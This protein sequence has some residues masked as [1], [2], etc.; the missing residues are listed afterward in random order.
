V[1]VVL[2]ALENEENA[3]LDLVK[4]AELCQANGIEFIA[5]PIPDRGVPASTKATAEL[6]RR[7]EDRLNG[8][9][10]VALHCRQGVGRS[11]LLAACLLVA[12]G[13]DREA[14]FESIRAARGCEVPDTAEQRE[15]V[16]R[17]VRDFVVSPATD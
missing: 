17:F 5:F 1:D 6:V 11:A 14:A 7:L 15:W 16:A 8:G 4:E 12:A 9:K 13:R 10:T 3:D 2:S